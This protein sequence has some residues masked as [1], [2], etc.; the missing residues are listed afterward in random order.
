MPGSSPVFLPDSTAPGFRDTERVGWD[1]SGQPGPC[2]DLLPVGI[3]VGPDLRQ[4]ASNH[5]TVHIGEAAADPVVIKAQ[6]LVIEA[7]QM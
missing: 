5:V 3:L 1:R 4:I 6:L 2:A 7:E